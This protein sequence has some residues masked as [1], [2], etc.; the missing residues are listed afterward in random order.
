MY[1]FS[2]SSKEKFDTLHE[3]LQTILSNLIKFY[4]FSIIE[5]HRSLETQQK[6]F[7][8]GKSKLDGINQKSKHQS[9]PSM[10]VD[11]MPYSKGTNA[12]EDNE[13]ERAR[14]YMMMGMVKAISMD[15]KEKGL[16]THDVRFG[17]DWD[18]DNTFRDQTFDDLP[19]FELV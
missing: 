2:N 15:L 19:H 6:Y 10:A 4:D 18:G 8:D 11:I 13:K 17:L 5:G 7:K 1:N 16:I 9:Y 3:D 12:F 14:F